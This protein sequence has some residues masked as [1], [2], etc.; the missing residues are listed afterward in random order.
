MPEKTNNSNNGK[1][2]K[3]AVSTLAF[4]SSGNVAGP[5]VDLSLT[6]P[7]SLGILIIVIIGA[8]G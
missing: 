6:L 7:I 3:A 4:R 5:A 8:G 1:N 2:S